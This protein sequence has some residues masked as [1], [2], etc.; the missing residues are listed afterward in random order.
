MTVIEADGQLV[1]PVVVD[2]LTIFA[3]ERHLTLWSVVEGVDP[4]GLSTGQRYSF[5]LHANNKPSN[6]W[7]RALPNVGFGNLSTTLLGGI[8][9][10]ILRY[11]TADAIEPPDTEEGLPPAKYPLLETNLHPLSDEVAE[12]LTRKP[13]FAKTLQ[14][15][16]T[17]AT[18][19]SSPV[20]T[21]NGTAWTVPPVPIML[22]ILSGAKTV[23][24]LM[25]KGSIY[26][27]KRGWVVEL[28][29]PQF[30]IGSP[31]GHLPPK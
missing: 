6:Y 10:A 19:C 2:R 24:E 25:P 22:Q 18:N 17:T 3:G 26:K 21:I 1:K 12:E 30:G 23:S 7:V 16:R 8:N 11:S 4:A 9:S 14:I 5:I 20:F 13:D 28:T 29:V 15:G 27:L 31:V